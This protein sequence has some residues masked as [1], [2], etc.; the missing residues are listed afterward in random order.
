MLP[1]VV[2]GTAASAGGEFSTLGNIQVELLVALVECDVD[3]YMERSLL[4]K[5]EPCRNSN[6]D[7]SLSRMQM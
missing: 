5:L 4:V 6:E 2:S 7:V 1:Q 3:V